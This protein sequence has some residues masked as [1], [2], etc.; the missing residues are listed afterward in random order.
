MDK[1]KIEENVLL[2]NEIDAN[3]IMGKTMIVTLMI[4]IL[5][6]ILVI[7]NFFDSPGSVWKPFV[8]IY[9]VLL[10]SG[11]VLCKYLN[12]QKKWLK[13]VMMTIFILVYAGLDAM[14]TAS[15]ALL[16]SIPVILSIRY[17]SKMFTVY[18]SGVTVV[19]FLFSAMLG[20]NNGLMDLN[21]L[22]LPLG[23]IINMGDKTWLG[24]AVDGIAYDHDLM[25]GNTLLYSYL[26]KLLVFVIIAVI[27]V[28]IANQG[29]KMVL[30]QEELTATSTRISA[31]LDMA[32]GIQSG[33]LPNVF[34]AFP[35]RDE[36]KI[37]ATMEP[38]KEVGGDFY[39]FFMIDSDH[40][41]MVVADVSGK[42]VPAALFMMISRTI[43]KNLAQSDRTPKEVLRDTN[44]ALAEDNKQN[45]FVTVWLGV[46]EL[47][48][49]KL[50]YA[51]AGHEKMVLY[52]DGGWSM[53][54]KKVS[55][56]ALGMFGSEEL[57]M[58]PPKRQF[59]NQEITLNPGDVIFQYTDGVTE[60]TDSD[61]QLFGENRLLEACK[62]ASEIEP[63][64]LLPHI[65][66]KIDDFV[67]AEPQFDDITMLGLIYNGKNDNE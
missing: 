45:M 23:T 26:P 8:I 47:S 3:Y 53:M 49:G 35:E 11:F 42:G 12:G 61:Q 10:V 62:S 51:D 67:K 31:E 48:T 19:V 30:K 58:L 1:D 38:A 27:A 60:A 7:C 32:S 54:E 16:M 33:L 37:F 5:A 66:A 46:L 29:R 21:C 24:E 56:V 40:L 59:E 65:R 14:F 55:G 20:A 25:V 28:T 63:K 41:G 44:N 39:D 22:E 52:H 43:I 17:F 2:K 50:T 4:L 18:V 64:E 57:E 13:Y 36:F 6:L 34:P 9:F 15:V